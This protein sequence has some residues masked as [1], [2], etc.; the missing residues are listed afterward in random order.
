MSY[1]STNFFAGNYWASNLFTSQAEAPSPSSGG[2]GTEPS[3]DPLETIIDTR[4]A[5]VGVGT[6]PYRFIEL[7][8]GRPVVISFYEPDPNTSRSEFYYNSREN[9]LFKRCQAR[10][11]FFWKPVGDC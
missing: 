3:L 10:N 2:D 6:I 1:W 5:A 11:R 9:Q 4:N 7:F 8:G